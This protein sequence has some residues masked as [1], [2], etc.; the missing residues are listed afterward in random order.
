MNKGLS[1][2]CKTTW[3]VIIVLEVREIKQEERSTSRNLTLNDL[4]DNR[5]GRKSQAGGDEDE[6]ANELELCEF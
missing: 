1:L 2:L 6:Y 5:F 4:D 3:F